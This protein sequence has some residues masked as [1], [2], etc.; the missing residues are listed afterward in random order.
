[1]L[2]ENSKKQY[3][4]IGWSS[5]SEDLYRESFQEYYQRVKELSGRANPAI[6]VFRDAK[7]D[8]LF[9]TRD[10][11]GRYWICRVKLPVEVVCDKRLDIGA[12]L[13]RK[14]AGEDIARKREASKE[15]T[16][17]YT[18]LEL[19][20][21][22][23]EDVL[24]ALDK[25]LTDAKS[26]LGVLRAELETEKEELTRLEGIAEVKARIFANLQQLKADC[27]VQAQDKVVVATMGT[28]GDKTYK[29]PAQ[30]TDTKVENKK[31]LPNTG[32]KESGL[33][34]FLGASIGLLALAGKR[35][36]NK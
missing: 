7:V 8:D 4:A 36:Y 35:K 24:K 19:A 27:D 32:T 16:D 20:L 33:L 26:K 1:M 12:V 15:A 2:I 21:T 10:L 22:N 14:S 3:V 25:E 6:N 13:A 29:A 9:W 23:R 17:T 18:I 31:Q 34:A 30:A 5:Q 28:K 11:D